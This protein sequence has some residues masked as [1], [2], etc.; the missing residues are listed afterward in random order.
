MTDQEKML[1]QYIDQESDELVLEIQERVSR[2]GFCAS[3]PDSES[4]PEAIA[5]KIMSS[6]MVKTLAL[7]TEKL[8]HPNIGLAYLQLVPMHVDLIKELTIKEMRSQ[9]E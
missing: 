9:V 6:A 8:G 1:W 4:A 7:L 3:M 2:D 5:M